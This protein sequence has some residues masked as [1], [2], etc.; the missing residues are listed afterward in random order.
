MSRR[1]DRRR[2]AFQRS[3]RFV[4]ERLRLARERL[5]FD[6]SRTP[7][8]SE[9]IAEPPDGETGADEADSAII[10]GSGDVLT[11][12]VFEHENPDTGAVPPEKSEAAA[13]F[14]SVGTGTGAAGSA[15]ITGTGSGNGGGTDGGSVGVNGVG[16]GDDGTVTGGAA[17]SAFSA[18]ATDADSAATGDVADS[19][20]S[21]DD[22]APEHDPS[23]IGR[24][25]GELPFASPFESEGPTRFH[26]VWYDEKNF[27]VE[28]FS[29]PDR[30]S[31]YIGREGV[32][33]VQM[34]G[35]T[36]PEIV[37]LVGAAFGL[38]LLAQEDI[39]S[40]VT[41]SKFDEYGDMMLAI[42][43][44][45]QLKVTAPAPPPKSG[46]G[47]SASKSAKTGKG[48]KAAAGGGTGGANDDADDDDDAD[49]GTVVCDPDEIHG[50]QI[51]LMAGP[52][53]VISFHENDERIFEPVEQRIK[54]NS[55]RARRWGPG[56]LFYSLFDTL[57]DRMLFLTEEIEDAISDLDDKIMRDGTDPYIDD[58]Y[59]LKRVV[60]R[61]SRLATPLRDT[62]R[63]IGRCEHQLFD[64]LLDMY[65]SD[66]NDHAL[67]VGDRV[68]SARMN[69]QEFQN[70]HNTLQ[71]RKTSDIIRVL[72]VITS[73]FIP[74][75]FIAGVYGMNFKYMPELEKT[76][77]YP[78]CIIL[79]AVF[80]ICTFIYFKRKKWI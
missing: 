22:D 36:D 37:H 39:L 66:L 21:D 10:G 77:G 15:K 43:N 6:A 3:Q 52:N 64:G 58:V 28:E 48:A 34:L 70:Y 79:M 71:E 45:V 1:S 65:F 53:F 14:S 56:Y 78:V 20:V 5:G 54:E 30:L 49:G 12:E 74:L 62:V 80:A 7:I 17:S 16:V 26:V 50:Q 29:D 51:S 42:A 69:L 19:A 25:P 41:R 75:T 11:P 40:E 57:V 31:P 60:G 23:E 32:T 27:T 72:T 55:G 61:L 4:N 35:L 46:K 59:N 73:I 24:A 76:Y 18:P 2:K 44:A 68:E 67:R 13:H 8:R 63:L 33:W 47:K 38:P 9:D